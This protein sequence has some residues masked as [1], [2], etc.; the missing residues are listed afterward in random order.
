[1]GAV[2]LA[3]CNGAHF[4]SATRTSVR[5]MLSTNDKGAIAEAH[6]IA[7]AVELGMGVWRPVVEGQRYDLILEVGDRLLRTQCKWANREGDVV[8][9]RARTSRHTPRGYVYTTYTSREIDGVAAWCPD[10][11][12][13]YFVPIRDIDGRGHMSLRLA[14][15]R[16]NQEL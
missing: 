13:C 9:V 14:P 2:R 7:A 8:V 15:A 6:I 3:P 12:E 11:A 16:N 5:V 10:T 4:P 1:M